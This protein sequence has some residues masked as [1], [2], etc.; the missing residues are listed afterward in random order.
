MIVEVQMNCCFVN[1]QIGFPCGGLLL[2]CIIPLEG[3]VSVGSAEKDK[4]A[5]NSF[6]CGQ[7][8]CCGPS[9]EVI[10]VLLMKCV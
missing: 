5:P 7:P 3:T 8:I 10:A 4:N 6:V 1:C 9:W 2:W